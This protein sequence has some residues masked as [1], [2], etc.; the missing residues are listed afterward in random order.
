[1]LPAREGSGETLDVSLPITSGPL[2]EEEDATTADG[3]G[4]STLIAGG[5]Q[6]S[7][8]SDDTAPVADNDTDEDSSSSMYTLTVILITVGLVLVVV[9]G[10]LALWWWLR[11]HYLLDRDAQ[12]ALSKTES[13]LGSSQRVSRGN[14]FSA[15]RFATHTVHACAKV[16]AV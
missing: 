1:M 2:E 11:S 10:F 5:D 4:V 8:G 6:P 9:A 13:R 12:E 14:R 7:P 3:A 16:S 15:V